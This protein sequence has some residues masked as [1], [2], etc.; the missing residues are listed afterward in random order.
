VRA[1]SSRELSHT[2]LS[3]STCKTGNRLICCSR[4]VG[5]VVVDL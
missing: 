4:P 5:D 3:R 1:A 2:S